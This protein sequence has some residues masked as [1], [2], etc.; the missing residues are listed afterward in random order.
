MNDEKIKAI[1]ERYMQ[2]TTGAAV[3]AVMAVADQ[4]GLLTTLAAHSPMTA[5]AAATQA[6]L[7]ERLVREILA[8]LSAAEFLEYDPTSETYAMSDECAACIADDSHERFIGGWSQII[9]GLHKVV[10]HVIKA[11]REGGGVPYSEYGPGMVAGM[12]R[13]SAPEVRAEL[14][15]TWLPAVPGLIERLRAGVTVADLGCGGGDAA[16]AMA[17]AFPK[18]RFVGFDT[19]PT[20][21]ER[22]RAAAASEALTNVSFECI[23]QAGIAREARFDFIIAIDVI[24]DVAHPTEVLTRV[25]EVLREGGSFLL[26]EPDAAD[27]LEDNLNPSGTLLYAMSTMHCAPISLAEGGEGV[28]AAWGPAR[29]EACCRAAGFSTF[30]RL[31]IEN[32]YNAFYDVR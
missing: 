8:A 19:D 32:S 9:G 13:V 29:A 23:G 28:G 30:E 31:P 4:T 5:A 17:K 11:C 6:G 21:I 14:T 2:A 15:S 25:R 22:A 18:S 3:M 1:T 16:L 10:P 24:H 26:V 20:S 27:K 12:A 7:Q